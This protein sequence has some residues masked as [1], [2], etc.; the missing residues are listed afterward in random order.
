MHGGLIDVVAATPAKGSD[1]F[2]VILALHTGSDV[3]K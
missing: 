3:Q 2:Q 1:R